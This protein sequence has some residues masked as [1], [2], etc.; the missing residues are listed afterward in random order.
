[1]VKLQKHARSEKLLKE[2]RL[3]AMINSD[4]ELDDEVVPAKQKAAISAS[5][6]VGLFY[7]HLVPR[8]LVV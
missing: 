5:K 1:M 6:Q 3:K 2:G 7:D 4:G 8:R